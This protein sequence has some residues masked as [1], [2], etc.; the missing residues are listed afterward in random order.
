MIWCSIICCRLGVTVVAA[1]Q[2]YAVSCDSDAGKVGLA[3]ELDHVA[4]GG[5]CDVARVHVRAGG[6]VQVRG[7]SG[8]ASSRGEA[9]KK[10]VLAYCLA[11]QRC[12]PVTLAASHECILA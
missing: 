3:V 7:Q 4:G 5:S 9:P 11:R 8:V 12:R 10:R 6:G 1:F 2:S